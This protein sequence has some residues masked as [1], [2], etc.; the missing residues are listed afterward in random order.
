S[1]IEG[2]IEGGREGGGERGIE[3]GGGPLVVSGAFGQIISSGAVDGGVEIAGKSQGGVIEIGR[4]L[5]EVVGVLVAKGCIK[6]ILRP[7]MVGSFGDGGGSQSGE[8]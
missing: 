1:G 4:T 2:W 3:P 7:V 8:G 5:G 6:A